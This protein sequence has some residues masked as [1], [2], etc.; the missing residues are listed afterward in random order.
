V[1][2]LNEELI[3]YVEQLTIYKIKYQELTNLVEEY[4]K[5]MLVLEKEMTALQEKIDGLTE[6]PEPIPEPTKEIPKTDIINLQQKP[7][8]TSL[9]DRLRFFGKK[10]DDVN[11][12]T[13]L[14]P[15]Q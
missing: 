4:K 11:Q 12:N 9:K 2:K 3:Q 6:E 13:T 7:Q 5:N 8:Q 15:T 1:N 14:T 10:R